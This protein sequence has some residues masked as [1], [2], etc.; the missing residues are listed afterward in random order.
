M[1]RPKI[2]YI[3]FEIILEKGKRISYDSKKVM[4]TV[5]EAIHTN[6]GD[7]G[8]AAVQINLTSSY[9]MNEAN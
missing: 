3:L 1:V 8:L 2:R 4:Q 6:Y 5:K 9:L 7:F